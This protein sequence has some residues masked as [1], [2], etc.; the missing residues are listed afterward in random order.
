MVA[1]EMAARWPQDVTHLVIVESVPCVTD[2]PM[3]RALASW[4]LALLKIVSPRLLA[5]FPARSLGAQSNSAGNYLKAALRRTTSH[6][7]YRVLRAALAYDG[8]PHLVTISMPTL[9]LVGERNTQTHKRAREMAAAIPH[10]SFAE[11][12]AAGHIANRDAP[13]FFNNIVLQFLDTQ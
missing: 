4:A 12:P 3:H 7:N 1:L 13:V 11:I 8:R 5:A 2:S 6:R 10:A 9:I